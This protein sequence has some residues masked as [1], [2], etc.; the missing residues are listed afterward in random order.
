MLTARTA[1]N[2]QRL[3]SSSY[4][5]TTNEIEF[6]AVHDQKASTKNIGSLEQLWLSMSS[7]KKTYELA[8]GTEFL[9]FKSGINPVWGGSPMN[10]KGGQMG[11]QV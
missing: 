7:L 5:Q 3:L 2:K 10:T 6:S 11:V 1:D 4:L 9:I 8:I